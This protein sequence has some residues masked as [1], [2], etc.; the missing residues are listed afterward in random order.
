M[1]EIWLDFIHLS[2][3]VRIITFLYVCEQIL[4]PYNDNLTIK[5]KF[6]ELVHNFIEDDSLLSTYEQI[7]Y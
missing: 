1:I 6:Y 5:E 4:V 7:D 3:Y 2:K